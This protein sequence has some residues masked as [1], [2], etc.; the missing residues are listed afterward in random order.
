MVRKQQRQSDERSSGAE[1]RRQHEEE[2]RRQRVMVITEFDAGHAE[3]TLHAMAGEILRY[4]HCV[5]QLADVIGWTSAGALF[6]LIRPGPI[7]GDRPIPDQYYP[8]G[9]I[10][11]NLQQHHAI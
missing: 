7:N 1:Q 4:R 2:E 6:G 11:W 8:G 9:S 3:A 5:R 10:D